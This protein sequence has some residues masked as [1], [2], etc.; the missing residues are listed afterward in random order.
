MCTFLILSFTVGYCDTIT[1]FTSGFFSVHVL[2]NVIFSAYQLLHDIVV[3]GFLSLLSIPV[4][5]GALLIARKV[6]KSRSRGTDLIKAAGT[7]L[8]VTGLLSA[9]LTATDVLNSQIVC[10]SIAF[11]VVVAMGMISAAKYNTSHTFVIGETFIPA[12]W[13]QTGNLKNHGALVV[14]AGF[15][16]GCL[17]GA[18]A[19]NFV[20]LSGVI[21]P[22]VLLFLFTMND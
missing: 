21:L 3:K 8:I 2:A 5:I 10:F 6:F 9:M 17:S 4:Y 7:L 19:G 1:F 16:A 20:G 13:S 12:F 15:T 11:L 22:G 18:A 14:L